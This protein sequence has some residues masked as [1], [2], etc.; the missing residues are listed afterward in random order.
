MLPSGAHTNHLG[1]SEASDAQAR[2]GQ[3]RSMLSS[4]VAEPHL[5]SVTLNP[6]A[7]LRS[8]QVGEDGLAEVTDV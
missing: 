5:C 2:D 7:S 4:A 3:L 8:Q 6:I 1:C